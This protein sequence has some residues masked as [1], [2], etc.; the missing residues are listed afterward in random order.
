MVKKRGARKEGPLRYVLRHGPRLPAADHAEEGAAE[1]YSVPRGFFNHGCTRMMRRAGSAAESLRVEQPRMDTNGHE[2]TRMG[3][4]PSAAVLKLRVEVEVHATRSAARGGA[5]EDESE[6][7][8]IGVRSFRRS[9]GCP[10]EAGKHPRLHRRIYGTKVCADFP[11]E[12][13]AV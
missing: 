2:R 10:P 8:G 7:G 4:P 12:A 3:R 11:N 13:C 1:G 9:E 5:T 6:I